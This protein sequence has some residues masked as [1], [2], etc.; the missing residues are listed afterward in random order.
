MDKE[1]YSNDTDPDV[2]R[3]LSHAKEGVIHRIAAVC[4]ISNLIRQEK[5]GAPLHEEAIKWNFYNS[6]F[7]SFTVVTT[8]GN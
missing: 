3:A 1:F 5:S 2:L 7:F 8:I 6:V 4:D